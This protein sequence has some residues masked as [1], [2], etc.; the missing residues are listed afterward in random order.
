MR[1]LGAHHGIGMPIRWKRAV[2]EDALREHRCVQCVGLYYVLSPIAPLKAL[3]PG[4]GHWLDSSDT[5]L[6]WESSFDIPTDV[7]PPRP[8]T[9]HDIATAMKGYCSELRPDVIEESGCSVCGQLSKRSEL[10]PLDHSAYD[11]TIL[12]QF[13]CTRMERTSLNEPIREMKGPVLD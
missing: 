13:G 6:E 5:A 12:E 1:S 8:T 4:R 3:K 2:C 7:Y 11:M 9:M 10:M